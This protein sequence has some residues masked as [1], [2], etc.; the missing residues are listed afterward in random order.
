MKQY[1][2]YYQSRSNAP[3]ESSIFGVY[4]E[5]DTV[6]DAL[7][8]QSKAMIGYLKTKQSSSPISDAILYNK[9]S[10]IY[11]MASYKLPYTGV[12]YPEIIGYN[13][14]RPYMIYKIKLNEFVF[15][16]IIKV[17]NIHALV[18]NYKEAMNIK[19]EPGY[20]YFLY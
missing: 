12:M 9:Y 18:V 17:E 16:N 6:L 19:T 5:Q 2:I 1:H 20:F 4:T 11:D 7:F 14:E 13:I 8:A 15:E 10:P 3:L